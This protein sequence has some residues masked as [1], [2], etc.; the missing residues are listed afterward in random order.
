MTT[1]HLLPIA[2]NLLLALAGR[3]QQPVEALKEQA[4]KAHGGHQ[5][6][7]CAEVAQALVEV[8]DKQFAEGKSDQGQAT[9]K[10]ILEYATKARDVAVASHGKMKET[11]IRLRE[12]HRRL[13]DVKH[14]L[15]ADDRPQVENIQKQ[16]DQF[17]LDILN[18]MFKPPKKK[19]AAK[20]KANPT[21]LRSGGASR[22]SGGE[23]GTSQLGL[24]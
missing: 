20:G 18:E 2:L 21:S 5:A 1:V 7:L 14:T 22:K 3:S 6:T 19:A 17:R 11:E 4:E 8:A 24:L 16:L 9:L 10:E 15:A 13:E 12:V 23:E